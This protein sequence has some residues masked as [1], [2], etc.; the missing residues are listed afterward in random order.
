MKKIFA[1]ILVMMWSVGVMSVGDVYAKP[2]L[3]DLLPS[4]SQGE[5][6]EAVDQYKGDNTK[7]SK[8]VVTWFERLSDVYK[9]PQ[10]SVESLIA[11]VINLIL[12]IGGTLAM[13]SLIVAGVFYIVAQDNEDMVNSAKKIITYSLIGLVVISVSFAIFT[14][15]SRLFL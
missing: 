10:G 2:K 13:L 8:V 3:D 4:Y 14:G 11:G 15:L 6:K 5:I 12:G 9:L 7:D 1:Y